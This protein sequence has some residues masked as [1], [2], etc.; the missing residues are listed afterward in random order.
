MRKRTISVLIVFCLLLTCTLTAFAEPQ[1]DAVSEL[2]SVEGSY[3]DDVG[4]RG[5]YSYHV[6]QIND[7]TPDAEEINDEIAESFGEDVES[8]FHHMEG[9][10]SLTCQNIGW[11]AFWNDHQLFLLL[12]AD[13]PT[14]LID[15]AAYGYDFD[16]GSR[17]TN[18]M[19]LEQRGISEEEY[20]ENLR[21]AAKSLFLEM[22]AGY[23]VD[24]REDG[25]YENLLKQTLE[26]QTLEQP[27]YLDRDGEIA[28]I[29]EI[30]VFAGAGRI[31]KLIRPFEHHINVIGDQYLIESCPETAKAGETVTIMTCDVT[32]G[33][34][35]IEVSGADVV[36]IDWFEY[37]FVMPPH[38]VEVSAE[39]IGNG[40]A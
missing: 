7:S 18:E 2:Y 32:D 36:S 38:D 13:T 9:G 40:L 22:N 39:F 19:I 6:P 8:E 21:E 12:S 31:S 35:V 3:T 16:T 28:V 15:Y 17:I 23:P 33:D 1:R 25:D 5:N 37:Q 26:W 10:F 34:K 29:T 20:L 27:M 30:R 4:N 14:D 11:K 24:R